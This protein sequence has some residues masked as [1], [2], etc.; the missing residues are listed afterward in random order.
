MK[1]LK[2]IYKLEIFA[3]IIGIFVVG[4]FLLPSPLT[5]TGYV[6]GIN[7]TIYAQSLD[8]MVDGSQSYTLTVPTGTL[9]LKSFMID[10]EVIGKGRVEI[11]LDNGKGVQ[12]MVYENMRQKPGFSGPSITGN[13]SITGKAIASEQG[14]AENQSES[15]EVYLAIQPK[16][17]INYEFTPLKESEEAVEGEFYSVCKETCNMPAGLFNSYSYELIFR[18]EKGTAVK[19]KE[20]KYILQE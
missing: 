2:S 3:A 14:S 6:S 17:P 7:M 4:M 12:Y 13:P 20:I 8:L 9:N 18:I 15:A 1:A 5:F 11:L 16:Q 10:G 19:I